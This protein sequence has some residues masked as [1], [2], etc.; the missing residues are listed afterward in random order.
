MFISDY[1]IRCFTEIVAVNGVISRY[2]T[3]P[4]AL[5][6]GLCSFFDDCTTCFMNSVGLSI[7]IAVAALLLFTGNII[8]SFFA[9]VSVSGAVASSVRAFVN[10]RGSNLLDMC[11]HIIHSEP[12]RLDFSL[13]F[14]LLKRHIRPRSSLCTMFGAGSWASSRRFRYRFSSACLS[15]VSLTVFCLFV[16]FST[17]CKTASLIDTFHVAESYSISH[18]PTRKLRATDALTHMVRSCGFAVRYAANRRCRRC[19]CCC[20]CRV[21]VC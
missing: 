6:N 2:A 4:K 5:S 8:V 10:P 16:C 7:A 11:Q 14:W 13:Y 18:E 12:R 9:I 1:W 21:R 20:C 17:L 3:P 19:C 15:I